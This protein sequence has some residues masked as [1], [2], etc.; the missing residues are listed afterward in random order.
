MGEGTLL[1]TYIIHY[2]AHSLVSVHPKPSARRTGRGVA[3][4]ERIHVATSKLL[5]LPHFHIKGKS[6]HAGREGILGQLI[7]LSTV[8]RETFEGET[9]TNFVVWEPP[10]KVFSMKFSAC[11]THMYGWFSIPRKFSPWNAHFQLICKS[12]L[13]RRFPAIP[14]VG[15]NTACT[16]QLHTY[17]SHLLSFPCAGR[18]RPSLERRSGHRD[19]SRSGG[20][21]GLHSQRC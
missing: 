15:E 8:Q 1:Y 9:F 19:P 17:Q 6:Q 12:F 18:S 10:M 7:S 3:C 16:M 13:P 14:Y 4:V 11:H 20:D 5:A 21:Q 2:S